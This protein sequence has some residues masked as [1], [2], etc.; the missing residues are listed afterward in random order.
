MRGQVWFVA[1]LI[2]G[3]CL[4][5]FSLSAVG[6]LAPMWLLKQLHIPVAVNLQAPYVVRVWA[7]RDVVLA[8]VVALAHKNTVRGLLWACI[9]ID[10]TDILSAHL[11]YL[12]GLFTAREA[13][14]L[15]FAAIA[16]LVPEAI[17]LG[18]LV[19]RPNAELAESEDVP[20]AAP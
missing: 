4:I 11:G 1:L 15:K 13:W 3:M 7:I 19:L 14:L 8:V 5:R 16:A 12:G 2:G 6:Y 18:L 20:G 9:A 17:A 10:T